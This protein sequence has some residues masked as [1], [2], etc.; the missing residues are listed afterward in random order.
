MPA[1]SPQPELTTRPELRGQFGMVSSTHWIATAVGMAMLERGGNAFDAAVAVGFTLQVVE[2]HLN[3]PGGEVPIIMQRADG[4][5]TVVCGQGTAPTAADP[6]AFGDL[7]LVPGT[8]VLSACVPG[9]FDAWMLLLRDH[10]TLPLREVLSPAI[11]YARRGYPVLPQIAGTIASVSDV[12]TEWWPSSAQLWLPGGHPPAPGSQH[13]NPALADTYQRIVEDAEYTSRAR[14]GQIQAAR[15]LWREGFVAESI[16]RFLAEPQTDAAGVPQRGLL[17]RDDL[18]RWEAT[19]ERPVSVDYG[20]HTVHK[21]GPWGQGPVFL[22]QLRL[23]HELGVDTLDQTSADF[24]HTVTEAAKLA[25]ADREAWYADPAFAAVPLETLLSQRYAAT[26]A[27]LVGARASDELRPGSPDDQAPFVIPPRLLGETDVAAG[28]TGEP[29]TGTVPLPSGGLPGVGGRRDGDTCHFDVVDARGN[30]VSATPSGGWLSSSP[31][32]PDLGFALGNRAQMFWLDHR[33]PAVI[34]PG[35]RP[36]TTLSPT[37]VTRAGEGVL[38]F[39]TPG[40]DQQ[41]QWSLTFL[42]RVLHGG[43]N[44]QRAIDA[45]M[46]HTN[47]FP[48]SFYPRE[49]SPGELVVES[50]F[51]PSVVRDLERR[52]HRITDAGPWAL[53]RLAA[54]A[55]DPET[56]V[57]RA[58]ANPRGNQG[59]A[60]GR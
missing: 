1:P 9:A 45:P 53:G 48:S 11:G 54:V 15:A 29:I 33:A 44:L 34:A 39:G 22:Q 57:L 55:R 50:R 4:P 58:G 25:F 52:G 17:S 27:K 8:G 40:G 41:D 60:A 32:I 26:R 6:A 7:G 38:A 42:L 19:Y 10:G 13:R 43:M 16:L 56:G 59:Y 36:R 51:G 35:K 20:D 30:M 18:A 5:P 23:L 3:G 46:F 31:T 49:M 28:A 21:T 14:E 37:L 24:V 2:P 12:F 47:S